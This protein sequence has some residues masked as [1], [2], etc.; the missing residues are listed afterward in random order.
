MQN[1][2]YNDKMWNTAY[3]GIMKCKENVH[4]AQSNSAHGSH[5]SN[6]SGP[7]ITLQ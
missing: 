3:L 7:Q 6:Q 5:S 4:T 1:N 2:Y